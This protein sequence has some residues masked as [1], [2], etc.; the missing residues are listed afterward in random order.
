M[1]SLGSA[2]TILNLAYNMYCSTMMKKKTIYSLL[3]VGFTVIW[4][5]AG[6][7]SFAQKISYSEPER[8]DSR[9]TT[10]EIIG[11]IGSN[12]LVF[13]NNHNDNAIS[14]YDND[15]KLL[16]R[17][18][19]DYSND[20]W[21]NVDFVPYADHAW[22][23]YQ[24]QRKNIV[25]CMAVKLDGNAKPLTD[26][27]E[28]DTTK[29]GWAAGNK[30]Y[31][32]VFSDDKEKILVFKI[33]SKNPKEFVFTTLLFNSNLKLIQN[34][35][36]MRIPMEEHNDYFTDFLVDND[37]DMI[38]GKFVRKNGSNEYVSDL[39]MILKKVDSSEFQIIDLKTG[40]RYLD[41]VKVKI[42]N[43]NKR[44]F[45]SALYYQQRRGNVEG[46]YTLIWDKSS[47]SILREKLMAFNDDLRRQ[48]KSQDA[49]L[50]LAFND[51]FIRHIIIRK[52]GGF[53]IGSEAFY[54]TS[55]YNTW[56]RWDCKIWVSD[57]T[58]LKMPYGVCIMVNWMATRPSM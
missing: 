31:T 9:R 11:K 14:V 2:F 26:P 39:H 38:F 58:G 24:Y 40:D 44:Y 42:D 8:D 32:T 43:T 27:I 52:D 10:F 18:K 3:A 50:R 13:K 28:L 17:V 56:N 35:Q 23:I 54:T 16:D 19:L 4:L 22:M 51:Y 20:H 37:G 46:L 29:I 34:K 15:M 7:S 53:L 45:F 48:A 47:G 21:I 12:Y 1:E 41:E 49:N 25:Y 5:T 33:N 30:I 57:G 6:F 36:S 55:R